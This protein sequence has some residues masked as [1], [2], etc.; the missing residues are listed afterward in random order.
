M[1]AS[2]LR[3]AVTT[4]VTHGGLESLCPDP[5]L[6]WRGCEILLNPPRGTE[7]DY[8]IVWAGC[9]ERDQMRVAPQ[10]TLFIAGEPPS[11]KI[12]PAKFYAQFHR[13]VS[14]HAADPH[15]RVTTSLPGL[16]WHVGLDRNT[17]RYTIGYRELANLPPPAKSNGISVVCSNL[18]TTEGQRKRLAFLDRLKS[19]LGPAV[20]HYGRGFTPIPDKLDAIL[21]QRFHLVLENC[22]SPDYWTE[23]LSDAYLGWAF[24]LYVGCPNLADHFPADGFAAIDPDQPDVAIDQIRALLDQPATDRET[25][26]VLHCRDL[27]LHDYNPFSRFAHWAHAFHQ[28]GLPARTC[29]ATSHKAFRPFPKNWLHRLKSRIKQPES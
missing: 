1:P 22:S 29:G 8:W 20:I 18:T 16:N 15:P 6:I 14:T 17:N 13:V 10:N 26:A 4:T 21:P 11:K 3:V 9:R 28:P 2:P 25:A 23:K 5:S 24:P 7:C 27:I 12:Y 19:A